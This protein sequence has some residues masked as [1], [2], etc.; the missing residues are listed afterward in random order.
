MNV[1]RQQYNERL[2]STS[3]EGR[4]ALRHDLV[5]CKWPIEV[6]RRLLGFKHPSLA[7]VLDVGEEVYVTENF[8]EALGNLRRFWTV[9]EALPVIEGWTDLIV[10]L[11]KR[12]IV[13]F[14]A[15]AN[16]VFDGTDGHPR[17]G[18]VLRFV[19]CEGPT[20]DRAPVYTVEKPSGCAQG[21]KLDFI[22][23]LLPPRF[24]VTGRFP[25][26]AL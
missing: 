26:S 5:R 9:D 16:S 15:C 4:H 2:I 6:A 7:E 12:N 25:A 17:I 14:I 1:L 18:N 11:Q 22:L 13:P 24:L 3:F 19:V 20:E 21:C 8:G 23:S 10:K